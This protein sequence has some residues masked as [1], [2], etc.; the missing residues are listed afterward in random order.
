LFAFRKISLDV[1]NGNVGDH[2]DR[3]HFVLKRTT[4]SVVVRLFAFLPA[5]RS[6]GGWLGQQQTMLESDGRGPGRVVRLLCVFGLAPTMTMLKNNFHN[7]YS[8]TA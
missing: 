7:S 6:I 4:G 5:A 1:S 2:F 8:S 3:V